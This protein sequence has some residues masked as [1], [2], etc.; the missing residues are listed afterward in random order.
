M[1]YVMNYFPFY[2]QILSE[3]FTY[4]NQNIQILM[5]IQFQE[6]ILPLVYTDMISLTVESRLDLGTGGFAPCAGSCESVWGLEWVQ[7]AHSCHSY[8]QKTHSAC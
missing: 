2:R 6:G 5:R 1:L 8:S 3:I 4:N 7:T